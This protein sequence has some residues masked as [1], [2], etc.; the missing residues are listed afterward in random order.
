MAFISHLSSS[1]WDFFLLS[2]FISSSREGLLGTNLSLSENILFSHT[3]KIFPLGTEFRVIFLPVYTEMSMSGL[4]HCWWEI[5]VSLTV[6]PLKI[7][8]FSLILISFLFIFGV[9]KSYSD[10]S[11]CEFL[12]LFGI[13]SHLNLQDLFHL[14][15]KFSA[16]IS[17]NIVS[18]LLFLFLSFGTSIRNI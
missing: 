5:I 12:F 4:H 7:S 18:F 8:T 17:L 10:M 14:F 2:W 15:W 13:Y 16:M 11:R 9:L 1:I 6:K 3:W